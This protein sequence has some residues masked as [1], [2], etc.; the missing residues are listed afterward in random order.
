MVECVC[1]EGRG[2]GGIYGVKT[3]EKR[4]ILK[5]QDFQL[6]LEVF[7]FAKLLV[8]RTGLPLVTQRPF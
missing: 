2:G 5:I 4:K 1:V 3:E 6:V 8:K 7:I